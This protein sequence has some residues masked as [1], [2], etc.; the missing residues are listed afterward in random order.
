M[1]LPGGASDKAGNSYERRWTVL[2]MT[3]L[4]ELGSGSIRIEVPGDVGLGA[5]FRLTKG[6]TS[7]WHQVKRQRAAGSW[8]INALRTSGVLGPWWQRLSSGD[9][10]HFVSGVG[11]PELREL[12]ERSRSATSWS[13]FDNAFLA[14][15]HPRENFNALKAAWPSAT[16]E[17]CFKALQHVD[18]VTIDEERLTQLIEYRLAAFVDG[19]PSVAAA[20][21]GQY[22]VDS[23]HH[24]RSNA[25]ILGFLARHGIGEARFDRSKL[26]ATANRL[27]SAFLTSSHSLRIVGRLLPMPAIDEALAALEKHSTIVVTG[28][29]GSGK[30]VVLTAVLDR[31]KSLDWPALVIAADRMPDSR[32]ARELGDALDLD[33]SPIAAL[34][35]LAAGADAVLIID[36]LDAVGVVSGRHPER[37]SVIESLLLEARAHPNIHVVLGCREFDLNNDRSLRHTIGPEATRVRIGLLETSQVAEVLRSV[38]I[39]GEPSTSQYEF[40][41]TPL[42]LAL[43]T[44]LTS[45][46]N[47]P[48]N[49]PG[50]LTELYD[51]FWDVKRRACAS[52]RAGDD[53]WV[54]TIDLLVDEMSTK[55]VLAVPEAVLDGYANQAAAMESEAVLTTL[56]RRVGFLH[57]TFFDYSWSRRFVA[58][59][60]KLAELLRSSEQDLFRRSQVRQ[61]LAYERSAQPTQY[62]DD[63]VWLLSS[64]DVRVHIQALVLSLTAAMPAPTLAEWEAVEPIVMDEGSVLAEHFWI[65]ARRNEGWFDTLDRIGIWPEWLSSNEPTTRRRA[66]WLLSGYNRSRPTAVATLIGRSPIPTDYPDELL[67]FVNQANTLIAPE[68]VDELRQT[69]DA[70]LLDDLLPAAWNAMLDVARFEPTLA[71]Q[72]AAAVLRRIGQKGGEEPLEQSGIGRQRESAISELGAAAPQP[73]VSHLVPIILAFAA[74]APR[75]EWR[76]DGLIADRTW[77]IRHINSHYGLDDN[78]LLGAQRAMELLAQ[79]DPASARETIDS[80]RTSNLEVAAIL[81]AHAFLGNPE[82]FADEAAEWLINTPGA[83]SLGYTDS[84]SWLSR[85]VIEACSPRMDSSVR[86]RLESCVRGYTTA[87]ERTYKGLKGRGF[88]ELTLLNGFGDDNLDDASR[89]RLGE[90]RRK[91]RVDD[92]PPP[93]GITG[94]AV[95]API[96]V[97]RARRMSDRQWIGAMRRHSSEGTSWRDGRL[98][99]DAYTQ[100][101]VLSEVTEADPGRFGRLYLELDESIASPYRDAIVRGLCKSKLPIELFVLV[102]RRTQELADPELHRSIVQLIESQAGHEIPPIAFSILEAIAMEDPDPAEDI[103]DESEDDDSPSFHSI[104]AASLNSTRGAAARAIGPLVSN[105]PSRLP[106][107]SGTIS[108]LSVDPTQQVRSALA[109]SLAAALFVD[110]DA[111]I[112]WFEMLLDG[113][114]DGLLGSSDVEIFVHYAL[115]LGF[116]KPMMPVLD[117]LAASSSPRA[118]RHRARQLTVCSI[119]DDGL[120]G[121]VDECMNGL[122]PERTGVLDVAVQNLKRELRRERLIELVSRGLRDPDPDVRQQAARAFYEIDHLPLEDAGILFDAAATSEDFE[123]VGEPALRALED[124]R[125]PLPASALRLCERFVELHGRDIGD[126]RTGAA[127]S[128]VHAVRVAIRFHAQQSDPDARARCLDV[129]DL[130]VANRAHGIDEGLAALER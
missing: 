73:F 72:L 60:G 26:A 39:V 111:A 11:A 123:S 83:L 58:R 68:L 21:L 91:F 62:D 97:E 6:E 92:V 126:I 54:E 43:L 106:N 79:S 103:W 71:P 31:A 122:A 17:E 46:G 120:D 2:K 44:E 84:P 50:S 105:D 74:R 15:Q 7:E 118:H 94:G 81:C 10:C 88:T 89:S 19:D 127:G 28:A 30:S 64:D 119:G 34:A 57:E 53:E 27:S 125:M 65:G 85:R 12:A 22:V 102:L 55:Q 77:H 75:P 124:Y 40:L 107:L 116:L 16:D 100:A 82:Q 108:A 112:G 70:G 110:A 8:S 130:L 41:R 87:W 129:I 45:D 93:Q 36:Q 29:A 101:Q 24:E 23:V 4:L 1:P 67:G 14:A 33:G 109:R 52:R 86:A 47:N 113:A 78:L 9:S 61:L 90:L 104:E 80:L 117:R 5:E 32:T 128:A 96:P 95:P 56:Q 99:G 69:I 121:F 42:N 20:V 18:V 25:D 66:L 98:I 63:V 49:F 114:S 35:A 59:S 3:E 51:Q 37:L 13:E 38:G 48:A 115:R 76:T